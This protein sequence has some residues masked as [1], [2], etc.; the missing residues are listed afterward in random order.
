V[1][2]VFVDYLETSTMHGAVQITLASSWRR[3]T[4]WSVVV[5]ASL[6]WTIYQVTG[7]FQKFAAKRIEVVKTVGTR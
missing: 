4:L 6:A 3:R 5:L 1:V 2:L 7:M